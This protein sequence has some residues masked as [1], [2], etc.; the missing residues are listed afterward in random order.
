[1]QYLSFRLTFA[2]IAIL[3]LSTFAQSPRTVAPVTS[4]V[5]LPAPEKYQVKFNEPDKVGA[6]FRLAAKQ[7][8]KIRSQASALG[9]VLQDDLK[10]SVTELAAVVTVLKVSAKGIAQK[11]SFVVEKCLKTT[12]GATQT[13]LPK[14]TVVTAAVEGDKV[15]FYVKGR[16]VAE[17]VR[18]MLEHLVHLNVDD[19]RDM[20]MF[21]PATPKAVGESWPVDK[22]KAVTGMRRVKVSVAPQ[23]I[24]GTAK[25]DSVTTIGQE[26]YLSVTSSVQVSGF[27]TPLPPGAQ[28]VSSD[29][30]GTFSSKLPVNPALLPPDLRQNMSVAFVMKV[31]PYPA[32]PEV[33]VNVNGETTIRIQLESLGNAAL[34]KTVASAVR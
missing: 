22:Q 27:T 28:L 15:N 32:G 6:Q 12:G 30:K 21:E 3:S 31:K 9:S 18:E 11:E 33:T 5:I 23:N 26:K 24:R 2:V 20:E 14:G 17:A 8:E 16:R 10:T 4:K 13:I 1:M 7:D 25:L 29:V 19:M 34:P